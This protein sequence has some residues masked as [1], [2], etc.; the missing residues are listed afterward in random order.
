MVILIIIPTKY[1]FKLKKESFQGH[2]NSN[3]LIGSHQPIRWEIVRKGV[4]LVF[5]IF[6]IKK[7]PEAKTRQKLQS[8]I[9]TINGSRNV[10]NEKKKKVSTFLLIKASKEI[11]EWLMWPVMQDKIVRH[12]IRKAR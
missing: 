8:L 2:S 3:Q 5:Y 10:M 4:A 7:I 1:F 12:I 11:T 6:Y 9:E